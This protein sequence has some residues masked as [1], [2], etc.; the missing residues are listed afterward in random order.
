MIQVIS[1][2]AYFYSSKNNTEM[3]LYGATL[4]V[5]FSVTTVRIVCGEPL[6]VQLQH[7]GTGYISYNDPVGFNFTL[8]GTQMG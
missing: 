4:L 3:M 6:V 2:F 8:Q 7:L 5:V 1:T